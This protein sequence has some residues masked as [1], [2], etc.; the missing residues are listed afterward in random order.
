MDTGNA[1]MDVSLLE[2]FMVHPTQV[3]GEGCLKV[4]WEEV[5]GDTGIN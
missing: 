1:A 5:V 2:L 3:H 4:Q